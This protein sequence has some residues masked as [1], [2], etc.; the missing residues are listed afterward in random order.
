MNIENQSITRKH[1]LM[2]I[3]YA[4]A[5]GVVAGLLS[6]IYHYTV[7][8]GQQKIALLYQK[9]RYFA[10]VMPFIVYAVLYLSQRYYLMDETIFGVAAVENELEHINRHV[11]KPPK[12][13]LKLAN[14]VLAL[15]SHFAVGQFGPTVYLGGAI[16]SNLG[17]YL[18]LP[19]SIIRLLIGCGVAAALSAILRTP[20]FAALIVVEIIFAKRYYDYMVPILISGM[21]AYVIDT[22][23]IGDYGFISIGALQ[24]I[25]HISA[26][27]WV[28][29]MGLAFGLG[30][31]SVAYT[32]AIK[33]MTTQFKKNNNKLISYFIAALL[34]SIMMYFFPH[35]LF[36][37]SKVMPAILAGKLTIA[38][39]L[40]VFILRFFA[41][42]LQ[43]GTG[44]YGGNFTPGLI[45]GIIFGVVI[46]NIL[47]IFGVNTFD[48]SYFIAFSIVGIF[49]GFGHAP[50]SA[51]VLAIE[52]S[53]EASTLLPFL[54]VATIAYFVS[55]FLSEDNVF[56]L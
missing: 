23:V 12:V 19:K 40:I 6:I 11:M 25:T 17:Y 31:I 21:V 3:L 52:L 4:I 24:K 28:V 50:I 46:Y 29:I 43:L 9:Y 18:K 13:L 1:R 53:G 47:S 41:T 7:I 48:L 55:E 45:I 33:V 27:D 10:F 39:L 54:A 49:A 36:F 2:I 35:F 38:T 30:I 34:T 14:T 8:N 16:G 22:L 44:I 32:I 51:V 37:E 15:S 20:L 56:N 42:T 26:L 5:I